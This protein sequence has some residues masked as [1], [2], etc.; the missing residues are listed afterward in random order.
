MKMLG[1]VPVLGIVTATN[2]PTSQANTQVDPAIARLQAVFATLRAGFD[3][4]DLIE[5]LTVAVHYELSIRNKSP[6][7]EA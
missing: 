5:V 6:R 7:R 1:G 4:M 3:I 2:V